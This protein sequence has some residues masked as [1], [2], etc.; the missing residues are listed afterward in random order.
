MTVLVVF[1]SMFGNTRVIA[2]AVAEAWPST[3]RLSRWRS[4]GRRR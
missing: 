4:A 2:D 1:E 3:C